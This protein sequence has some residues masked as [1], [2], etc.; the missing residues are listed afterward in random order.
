MDS[1]CLS[2]CTGSITAG[3]A[4]MVRYPARNNRFS[5][6][7]ETVNLAQNLDNNQMIWCYTLYSKGIHGCFEGSVCGQHVHP[8]HNTSNFYLWGT[9]KQNVYRSNLH[10]IEELK[11]NI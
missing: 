2:S 11:E 5:C 10:T 9:I 7:M 8:Y 1:D 4:C 3:N 6:L